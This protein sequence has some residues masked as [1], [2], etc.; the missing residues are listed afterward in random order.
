MVSMAQDIYDG[1]S[2]SLTGEDRSEGLLAVLTIFIAL[3]CYNV[4][5][6]VVL[7][8]ST[9]RRW[10]GLYFWSLLISGVVGVVPYSIGFLLKFFSH[11][12]STFSVSILTVGWW[13][14]VTG[15]SFVL[16]SRL[17]L[18]LRDERIL[19]RVLYMIIA[20][21]FLLHVPTTVLTYGAN[22]VADEPWVVG[23]NVMEKIQMTG[24]TIQEVI[25]S[26]LYVWET[27]RML[28][29]TSSRENRK[30]MHQLV[31]INVMI[32]T[33]DLVLLGLEGSSTA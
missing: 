20:N 10:K 30:I 11:V 32:V 9:F 6:L 23:Y 2:G 1:I 18:V 24:F 14:M 29:L 31:G 4:L 3:S 22:V 25:I 17:H 21:V 26:V 28:Q 13:T 33:M 19:H 12:D 15:Q 7:V 27:I 8:L 5:E 16:Y